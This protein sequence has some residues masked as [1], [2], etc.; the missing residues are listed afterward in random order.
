[1]SNYPAGVT[2]NEYEIA[3]ADAEYTDERIVRCDNEECPKFEVE[4][5]AE[6][7]I[8]SYS[9]EEWWSWTCPECKTTAEFQGAVREYEQEYE[10][11]Y[12][13]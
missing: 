5:D 3:G 13:D 1:M 10:P 4:L 7:D 6:V 9:H 12:F 8:Q 2:G 11:D